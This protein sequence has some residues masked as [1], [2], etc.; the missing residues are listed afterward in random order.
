MMNLKRKNKNKLFHDKQCRKYLKIGPKRRKNKKPCNKRQNCVILHAP[1]DLDL[2]AKT[3]ESLSFFSEVISKANQCTM[4]S[5]LYFDLS[6][7]ERVSPDAIMYL[8]AIISNNKR[9][10]SFRILC[11]G[12][13]PEN[14]MAK[15]VFYDVGF[16][17]FVNSTG[18]ITKKSSECMR[19]RSGQRSEPGAAAEFCDFA[20][21]SGEVSVKKTKKLFPMLVELMANTVQHAYGSNLHG[22]SKM[23]ANWY[24]FARDDGDSIRF[25]Y[26]DTGVGIPKTVGRRLTEWVI[27]KFS[28]KTDAVFLRTALTGERFRSET[29]LP[30]RGN[31]L[32]EIYNNCRAGK[33][34]ELQIISGRAICSANGAELEA[35][36]LGTSFEGTLFS[37]RIT[38]GE[39]S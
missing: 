14:N 29:K 3:E 21:N 28:S 27:D 19:I 33:I 36:S 31:G 13:M 17:D 34:N 20:N 5:C 4:D 25:I 30:Y 10:R 32:P 9:I 18:R 38:K 15:Q 6:A 37:W 7:I 39:E 22:E 11:R 35:H 16:F 2:F 1:T 26:L 8:I 24:V 12:N 23:L